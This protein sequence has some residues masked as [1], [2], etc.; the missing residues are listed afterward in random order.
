MSYPGD[1]ML[2]RREDAVRLGLFIGG[3][4]GLYSGVKDCLHRWRP[5]TG[6]SARCFAA[7]TVAGA[8]IRLRYPWPVTPSS[9]QNPTRGHRQHVVSQS[10]AG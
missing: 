1:L 2:C 8:N 7:G 10:H 5:A 4:T 6:A 9:R 3:F